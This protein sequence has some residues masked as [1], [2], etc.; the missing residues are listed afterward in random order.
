MELGRQLILP[1]ILRDFLVRPDPAAGVGHH[2]ALRIVDGD[3]EPARYRL[4]RGAQAQAELGGDL[5]RDAARAQVR[6]AGVEI[7]REREAERTVDPRDGRARAARSRYGAFW[8]LRRGP[9]SC[10]S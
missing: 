8:L 4:A 9:L 3:A 2:L 6:H 1:L 7:E 5:A 10:R